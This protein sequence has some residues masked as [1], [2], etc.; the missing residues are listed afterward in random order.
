MCIRDSR[1]ILDFL[2]GVNYTHETYSN[3]AEI[4]P[5]TTPPTFVSYGVTHKYVALTLGEELNQKMG[6]STVLTQNLDF[7]PNLQQTGEYR[8]TFNLGTVTKFNK[9][10]GWQNQFGDIYVSNPPTGSKKN[11]VI[12]TT[13]L[14]ISFTR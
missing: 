7:Y 11:D 1:T 12:F 13:G 3:G 14:N 6:K 10:L 4:T 2:G 5:V 8:A 9:W